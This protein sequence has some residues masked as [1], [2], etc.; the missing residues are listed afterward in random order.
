MNYK[1][2]EHTQERLR[3]FLTGKEFPEEQEISIK[4][5]FY[6]EK[7]PVK[8]LKVIRDTGRV[9]PGEMASRIAEF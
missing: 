8:S 4:T 7:V 5:Q 9:T 6:T 2:F 3:L 1:N